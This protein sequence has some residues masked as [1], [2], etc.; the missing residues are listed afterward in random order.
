[1]SLRPGRSERTAAL[2][3]AW[4]GRPLTLSRALYGTF[5]AFRTA[6]DDV[7]A[8]LEGT[9]A[10]PLA[11]VVFAPEDGVDARLLA[12][13]EYGQS[14]LFAYEVSLYRL[15][16]DRGV[17]VAAVA[18]DGVGAIAAA[19]VAGGLPLRVAAARSTAPLEHAP[20]QAAAH[21]L[22]AGHTT[23]LECGPATHHP[24]TVGDTQ[25]LLSTLPHSAPAPLPTRA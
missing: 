25:T 2:F 4:H 11:V 21:L 12:R 6:F 18:G 9:L 15:W 24:A 17:R 23:L 1:M 8:V 7:C 16:Q 19:H 3:P 14:A 5:P 13:A 20:P 10:L 22:A